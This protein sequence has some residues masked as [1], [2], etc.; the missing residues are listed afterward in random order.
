VLETRLLEAFQGAQGF[1]QQP[2]A[3]GDDEAGLFGDRNEA[4][5]RMNSPLGCFQ[6][7]KASA[8]MILPVLRSIC[9]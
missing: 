9:G 1:R 6:R 3:H 4:V 7:S 8:P 5:G 2:A